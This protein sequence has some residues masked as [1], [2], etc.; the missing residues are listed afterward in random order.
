MLR[1]PEFGMLIDCSDDCGLAQQNGVTLYGPLHGK[2]GV[3]IATPQPGDD[4]Q[5][6]L[7]DQY[8]LMAALGP[9]GE[10]GATFL[11][12][13]DPQVPFIGAIQ[14]PHTSQLYLLVPFNH[15]RLDETQLRQAIGKLVQCISFISP[16]MSQWQQRL[17]GRMFTAAEAYQRQLASSDGYSLQEDMTFHA[18]GMYEKRIS[19]HVSVSGGGLSLGRVRDEREQGRWDIVEVNGQPTLR[20]EDEQCQ[21]HHWSLQVT[22]DAVLLDG[23]RFVRTK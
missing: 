6:N 2:F 20:L 8:A 17:S 12:R 7:A 4:P 19:G 18:N 14:N 16:A 13:R 21:R 1:I 23:R 15:A 11:N 5:G 3:G 10:H 9:V 22:A